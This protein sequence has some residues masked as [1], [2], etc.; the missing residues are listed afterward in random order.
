MAGRLNQRVCGDSAEQLDPAL[1]P[2]GV[3]GPVPAEAVPSAVRRLQGGAQR[4]ESAGL[5]D[6]VPEKGGFPPR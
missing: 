5:H 4:A 1:A 3:D 2:L 6:S